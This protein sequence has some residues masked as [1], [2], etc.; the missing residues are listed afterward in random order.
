[1]RTLVAFKTDVGRV[2]EGN[3]DSVLIQD[4]V[5]AVADGMGGHVAGD[6]ASQTAIETITDGLASE[7]ALDPGNLAK[8]IKAANVAIWQKAQGDSTL[9][10]MGTTCTVVLVE[11]SRIH[12]G[13]VGDSRAYLFRDG[14]LEQLTEDHTLVGRMV[15]EGRLQPEEAERHPQRNIITRTLGVDPEVQVDTS[16]VEVG[17][18]D[19]IVICSDGLTS[20]LDAE[21]ITAALAEETEPQAAVDRLVEEANAAGGEDNVTVVIVEF[22]PGDGT[23]GNPSVA[24]AARQT[25]PTPAVTTPRVDTRPDELPD[26][27]TQ[28]VDVSAVA[29]SDVVAE[30]RRRSRVARAVVATIL[31]VAVLAVGGVMVFRYAIVENSYFVGVN[32][33]GMVTI[34]QGLPDEVAGVTFKEEQEVSAIALTD[35]PEFLQ[36]DVEQGIEADSLEDAKETVAN[37]EQRARDKEFEKPGDQDKER[38]NT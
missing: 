12:I 32:G 18:G 8:L 7:R 37:L 26:H 23:V 14:R 6:V 19:R 24:D 2:R 17:D 5:F 20:M 36:S 1:M 27:F 31:I 4:P 21:T 9:R 13:H 38:K 22:H 35:L 33:D 16:S 10:G 25:T 11:N 29:P 15:K 28:A 30:P 34:Y 3:E